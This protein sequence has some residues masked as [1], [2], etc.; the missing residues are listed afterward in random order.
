MGQLYNKAHEDVLAELICAL[1]S[2]VVWEVVL[3]NISGKNASDPEFFI[4]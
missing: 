2:G 1:V 4:A 3:A